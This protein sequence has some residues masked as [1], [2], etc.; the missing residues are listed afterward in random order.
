MHLHQRRSRLVLQFVHVLVGCVAGNLEKQFARQRIAIGVQT[1]RREADQ[2]IPGLDLAAG[3]QFLLV[4]RA[5]DKASQVV[6][7]IGV[8]AGHLRRFASD[9][10][11]AVGAAGFGY[12]ADHGLGDFVVQLADGQV[13]QKEQRRR[14]LDGN[15]VHTV[16]DQ[17]GADGVVHSQGKRHLQ[18]GADAVG[19]RNQ[20]RVGVLRDVQAEEAAKPANLAQHLLVEGFLRKILDALLGAVPLRKIHSGRSVGDGW[21]IRFSRLFWQVSSE[22]A[23]DKVLRWDGMGPRE[24][25]V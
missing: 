18:L 4:H 14:A 7:S 6:L 17:V 8:E 19:A 12:A 11:A 9:Q 24:L 22:F 20:D 23:W 5:D 16:V 2:H 21:L 3:D 13:V 15:V 25:P 1:G 10:R